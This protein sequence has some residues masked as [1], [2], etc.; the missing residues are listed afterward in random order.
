MLY[1]T[2]VRVGLSKEKTDANNE[3]QGGG[4]IITEA[5]INSQTKIIEVTLKELIRV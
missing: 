3:M 1:Q 2:K 5:A 4:I